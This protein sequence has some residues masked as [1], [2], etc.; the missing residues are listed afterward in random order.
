MSLWV[1]QLQKVCKS[2]TTAS[3]EHEQ[4]CCR[5]AGLTDFDRFAVG[6]LQT[7]PVGMHQRQFKASFLKAVIE[8]RHAKT[9]VQEWTQGDAFVRCTPMYSIHFH[10]TCMVL[11]KASGTNAVSACLVAKTEMLL[12]WFSSMKIS[13]RSTTLCSKKLQHTTAELSM[14]STNVCMFSLF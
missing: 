4:N 2:Y 12:V 10:T 3:E 14:H 11:Q 1:S 8:P 5:L 7:M 6:I 9:R 13:K